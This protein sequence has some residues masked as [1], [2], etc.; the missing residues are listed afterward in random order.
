MNIQQLVETLT[1]QVDAGLSPY[2][3]IVG[4]DNATDGWCAITIDTPLTDPALVW[5][6]VD[7]DPARE[8]DPRFD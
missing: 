8:L 6:T 3:E 1:A 5:V 7:T 4:W 2:T